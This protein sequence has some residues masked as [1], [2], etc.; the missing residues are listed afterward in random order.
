MRIRTYIG[1]TLFVLGAINSGCSDQ[2]KLTTLE[3]ELLSAL[4]VNFQTIAQ[5][6][7]NPDQPENTLY[8]LKHI[9]HIKSTIT[10]SLA[11][12]SVINAEGRIVAH[13]MLGDQYSVG[14]K[15]EDE[16]TKNVIAY[17]DPLKPYF[18]FIASENNA[19]LIDISLPVL[20]EEEGSVPEGYVRIGIYKHN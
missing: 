12:A 14:Q 7:V 8:L 15:L 2:P 4:I 6:S 17:H 18:Q 9:A 5:G 11:Y 3:T 10:A 13:N 20:P 1:I 19:T 16:T